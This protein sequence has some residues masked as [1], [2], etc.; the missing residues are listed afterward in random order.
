LGRDSAGRAIHVVCAP[1]DD[2][3]AII[4][5]YLPNPAQ[6]DSTFKQRR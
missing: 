1:K 4:T 2:F 6:W 5:A 3:L